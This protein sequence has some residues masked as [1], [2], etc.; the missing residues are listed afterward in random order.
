MEASFSHVEK[1]DNEEGN[2]MVRKGKVREEDGQGKKEGRK[3]R[4][5][6]ESKKRKSKTKRDGN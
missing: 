6:Q 3:L 4:K 2:K 5:R 1:E